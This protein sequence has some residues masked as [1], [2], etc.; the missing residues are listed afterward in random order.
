MPQFYDFIG[1]V[2]GC[3]KTLKALLENLGYRKNN[4]YYQHKTRQPIF[5]GDLI[6]SGPGQA[7][8][9]DIVRSMHLHGRAQCIMGNHELNAI[10]F[11]TP[12]PTHIPADPQHETIEKTYLRTRSAQHRR[13][14]YAFLR[15][16]EHEPRLWAETIDWFKTL[17]LWIDTPDFRVIHACW[18][19]ISF[20][21]LQPYPSQG[22]TLSPSLLIDGTQ[23]G[24]PTFDALETLLKGKEIQLP[25][26]LV[27]IDRYNTKRRK[28]RVKWW[29][30]TANTFHK[31]FLGP[32][33]WH[34]RIPHDPIDATRFQPYAKTEKPIFF[35]HYW[36]TGTPKPLATNLACLDYSVA[37]EGGQLV[38]YRWQGEAQLDAA[39]FV[40]QPRVDDAN[41]RLPHPDY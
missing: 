1:D 41:P 28:I 2:H 15:E 35:G 36:R 13:Q 11:Y 22:K 18:D 38:A 6:D 33:E 16:H 21:Q 23:K 19:P 5:L 24:H 29:D 30:D 8:T 39:N 25:K 27:F 9:I 31:A 10:A 3:A 12:A 7:E 34:K 40:A 17:P 37:R 26:D 32:E 4:N 20:Q 14:H